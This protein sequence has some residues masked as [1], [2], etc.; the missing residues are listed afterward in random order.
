MLLT[1]NSPVIS[2]VMRGQAASQ[3]T[4]AVLH[5]SLVTTTRDICLDIADYMPGYSRLYAWVYGYMD[6]WMVHD[7]E[8]MSVKFRSHL[9]T[10]R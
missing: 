6:I 2:Q 9:T 10:F 7:I 1:L 4:R 3:H 5:T 8:N